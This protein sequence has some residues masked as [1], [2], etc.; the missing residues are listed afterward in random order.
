MTVLEDARSVLASGPLC[1]SCLGRRFAALS[2]GLTNAERGRALRTALAMEDDEPYE[3][4]DPEACWVCEGLSAT[5]DAWAERAVDALDDVE[6]GTY[7]VGTRPPPLV[8]ENERLLCE[9]AGVDEDLGESFKSECNREVGKR[10]GRLTGATVDFGR[11]D[12]LFVLE[13]DEGAVDAQVNPAFV[14]GRYRKLSREIPQT[15]WPC[16]ECGGSGTRAGGPC[17]HCGGTGYLYEQ[18]V[19]Q[20]VSPPIREAMGGED[21]TFHGA[22]REDID[23]RMLGTGRPFV[24]E[25]KRPRRRF[26]DVEA[27]EVAVNEHAEGLAEVEGLGLATHEMVE[28]VKELDAS[29]TY[30]ARVQF[31]APVTEDDFA[32]AVDALDGATIE[33]RTPDRVSHRRAAK[34]RVREAYAVSG[35]L[36]DETHAVVEIHGEGGLYI[37]ELVSGD[38]GRTEPSLSGLVGVHGYVTE[39]DVLAVEGETEPFEDEDYFLDAVP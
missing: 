8:E 17:V 12:V 28:R 11:P 38:G 15:E 1:D 21:S 37:K 19:E 39:L 33:Q 9:T 14:Y 4:V 6:F 35:E 30:R 29:K 13:I 10:V 7:Q 22:G 20:L 3:E 18:S 31:D 27:L 32:A 25:V 16:R 26:P 36:A 24:V 5:F 2:F 34:T 23:A